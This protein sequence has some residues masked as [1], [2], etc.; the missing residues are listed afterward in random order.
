LSVIS[1]LQYADL[2]VF[3]VPVTSG[4]ELILLR[5]TDHQDLNRHANEYSELQEETGNNDQIIGHSQGR[6][7]WVFDTFADNRTSGIYGW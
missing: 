7:P 1:G 6:D 3:D 2:K 4:N 5:R